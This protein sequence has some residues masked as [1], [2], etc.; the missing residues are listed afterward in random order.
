MKAVD[1]P[2]EDVAWA[3]LEAE[4]PG[5]FASWD[6]VPAWLQKSMINQARSMCS[7]ES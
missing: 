3:L 2:I 4:R 1:R 6:Q 7:S 5:E